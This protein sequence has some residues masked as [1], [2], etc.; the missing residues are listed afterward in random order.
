LRRHAGAI[1]W[2]S[3]HIALIGKCLLRVHGH[4]GH[5]SGGRHMRVL[6]HARSAGLW[7]EVLAWGLLGGVYLIAPIDTILVARGRFRG[8]KTGL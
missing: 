4:V 1:P 6:W 8:I 5:V 7:R 3:L 2:I